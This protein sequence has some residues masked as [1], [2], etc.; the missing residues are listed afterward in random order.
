MC[1][2]PL[3]L[4][5]SFSDLFTNLSDEFVGLLFLDRRGRERERGI[6]RGERER[7]EEKKR[8][9]EEK[10]EREKRGALL[11]CILAVFP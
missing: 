4:I 1:Y 7:R 5:L 3:M 11:V 6:E 10:R 9:E 8:R 2:D